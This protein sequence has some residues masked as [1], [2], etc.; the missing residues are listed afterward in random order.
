LL[1][2]GE[3]DVDHERQRV[4]I[5]KWLWLDAPARIGGAWNRV[6]TTSLRGSGEFWLL[7]VSFICFVNGDMHFERGY[8]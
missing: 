7:P 5:D 8:L 1:F 6:S 4:T 2:G 3:I